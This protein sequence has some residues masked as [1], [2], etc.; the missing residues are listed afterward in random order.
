M[1]VIGRRLQQRIIIT[2]KSGETIEVTLIDTRR[3][4]ARI[5]FVADRS[6]KIVREELIETVYGKLPVGEPSKQ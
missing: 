1:L 5:G 2:T 6:I 4:Q 3:D